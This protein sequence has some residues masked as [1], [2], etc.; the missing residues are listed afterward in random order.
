MP[1]LLHTTCDLRDEIW[2][3]WVGEFAVYA[4][5]KAKMYYAVTKSNKD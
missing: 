5:N 1:Q 3:E 4:E 2:V